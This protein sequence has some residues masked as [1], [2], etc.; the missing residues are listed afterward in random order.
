MPIREWVRRV[1]EKR[2]ADEE[3]DLA[4][5]QEDGGLT[6]VEDEWGT[7]HEWPHG[8]GPDALAHHDTDRH[9]LGA[10]LNENP[11]DASTCARREALPKAGFLRR[12]I[13]PLRRRRGRPL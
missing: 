9:D 5:A 1:H 7:D 11:T 3:H 10:G 4:D 13:F 8:D 2:G 6:E 12:R